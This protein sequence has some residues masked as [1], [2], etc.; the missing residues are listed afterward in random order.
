MGKNT[1]GTSQKKMLICSEFLDSP[2]IRLLA[3][4]AEDLGSILG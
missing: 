4:T 1:G 3:F 2:V